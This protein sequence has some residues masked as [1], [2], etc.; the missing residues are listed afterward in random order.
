MGG[1][2]THPAWDAI[3]K[4][5]E[6]FGNKNLDAHVRRGGSAVAAVKSIGATFE[7]CFDGT[8]VVEHEARAGGVR[9]LVVGGMDK[10]SSLPHVMGCIA[11][12][13]PDPSPLVGEVRAEVSRSTGVLPLVIPVA[14]SSVDAACELLSFVGLTSLRVTVSRRDDGTHVGKIQRGRWPHAMTVHFPTLSRGE[15]RQALEAMDV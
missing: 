2:A 6:W 8:G 4:L 11:K 12:E 1:L 5:E 10:P 15:V 3:L 14:N 13:Q 9:Q 7:F